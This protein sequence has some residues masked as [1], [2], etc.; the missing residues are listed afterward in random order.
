VVKSTVCSSRGA[1]VNSQQPHSGP[2][3]LGKKKNKK[4]LV[5]EFLSALFHLGSEPA[6]ENECYLYFLTWGS[7]KPAL[8]QKAGQLTWSWLKAQAHME[9]MLSNVLHTRHH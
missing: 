1:E 8:L 6:L 5:F 7:H 9:I 3:T 2:A 4:H